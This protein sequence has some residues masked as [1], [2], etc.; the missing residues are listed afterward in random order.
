MKYLPAVTHA[1]YRG[2]YCVH[3]TFSDGSQNTIDFEPWLEGPVFEPLKEPA[4][5]A[6]FF[7]DGGT[8]VWPNGADIAPETLYDVPGRQTGADKRLQPKKTRRRPAIR[9]RPATRLRG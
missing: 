5:F 6:R 3:V 7:V 9:R 4:R 2:D 8:V 1:E